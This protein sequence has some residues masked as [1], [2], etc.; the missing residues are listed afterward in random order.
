MGIVVLNI[1]LSNA[2][3]AVLKLVAT[4]FENK[5]IAAFRCV[6]VDTVK[7]QVCKLYDKTGMCNRVELTNWF[8]DHK[9]T[10]TQQ[11]EE[12]KCQAQP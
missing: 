4:G 10:I 9:L 7:K 8:R 2:E 1:E 3:V 11:Q 5:E 12:K 6:G